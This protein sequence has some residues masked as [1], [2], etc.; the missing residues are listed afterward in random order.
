MYRIAQVSAKERENLFI[1]AANK[2]NIKSAIIEKDF[3]VCFTLDYL[4]HKSKWKDAFV[5]KGGT[6]LSKAYNLIERFSEDIDLILDWRVLGYKINEPWE[7]RSN[8]KQQVFLEEARNRLFAFLKNEFAP[9]FK[10]DLKN[11][12]EDDYDVYIDDNDSGVV[13]FAYPRTFSSDVI[14]NEIRLEIGAMAAFTPTQK[15]IITPYLAQCYPQVFDLQNTEILTTTPE[16]TFWEKA[17]ILHQEAHRPETSKIPLRYSRHYYDLY[18]MAN[19]STK[20]QAISN[21]DLLEKVTEFKRKFYPRGWARY[22]LAKFGTL[23]LSPAKHSI[24]VL[25]EDY[26]NMQSMIYGDYPSFD[27]ILETIEKLEKEINS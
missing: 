27:E 8:T 16:R 1:A 7:E 10:A 23:K 15:A 21:P 22:D 9:I 3:W 14:L 20:N 24:P 19:T 11:Y 12:I 5:F 26:K 4:F 6:S 18:C 13:C 25:K 2:M 17:T